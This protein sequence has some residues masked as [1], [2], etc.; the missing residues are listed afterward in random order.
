[1]GIGLHTGTVVVGNIGSPQRMK[2]GAVGS[3][4]NL[5]S[6]I[7]SYTIGRQILLSA[8]TAQA[9]GSHLRIDG[10]IQ[11][12]P[13]GV[14]EVLTLYDIGG[15][16][17]PYNLFLPAKRHDLVPLETPI[18]LRYT[19]L[20][21]KH[22]GRTVFT[23]HAVRLSTTGMEIRTAHALPALS[24]VKMWLMDS[25]GEALPGAL[26][27]KVSGPPPGPAAG[28]VVRFTSVAPEAIAALQAICASCAPISTV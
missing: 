10:E 20:E 19:V 16:G 22:V 6:R 3:H 21:E 15:I 7:E 12:E 28:F 27:G 26:Y 25:N 13:K 2:Y 23:G 14:H 18:A 8:D 5:T 1:M 9:I 11:V 4:V 24:N 17:S